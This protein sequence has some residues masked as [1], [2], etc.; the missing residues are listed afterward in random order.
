MKKLE[1]N[2]L[3]LLSDTMLG[4]FYCY[5]RIYISSVMGVCQYYAQE[6]STRYK[7]ST[8]LDLTN[9]EYEITEISISGLSITVHFQ[10]HFY[11]RIKMG[12]HNIES[13]KFKCIT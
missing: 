10:K 4:L 8:I 3:S 6:Y 9:T 11:G 1:Q 2:F 12:I 7:G 5:D 13:V